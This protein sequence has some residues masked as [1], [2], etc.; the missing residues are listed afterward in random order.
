MKRINRILITAMVLVAVAMFANAN[1]PPAPAG[2]NNDTGNYWVNYTWSKELGDPVDDNVNVT[3]SFNV[4]MNGT[5]YNGT[6]TFLNENVGPGGWANITVWAYNA[7]GNGNMSVG[8]VSDNVQAP[9][10]TTE[11]PHKCGYIPPPMDLSHLDEI[12]VK[13]IQVPDLPS[14]FDWRDSGNVTPVKDQDTCGTCWI[15]GTTSV[16]ESAVLI[17]EGAECIFSEQGVALCVDRSWTY[18]YDNTDDPCGGGGWSWLAAEAFIKKGSVLE[19]CNPY[20]TTALNCD[21]S[22]VCD[23][24]ASVKGVD[25]YRLATDNG[26][27]IDV[28]KN[29]V[30]DHG[31]VTMAFYYNECGNY[32]NATWGTIYDYYPSPVSANH[33]VSIIGWNDSVP[34]PNQSHDGTGAWIVKNSW[35]TDWGNDGFFYLA[36]NS[37]CVE[38]I[39]YLVYKNP[40]P[41]EELLYWDEAG[42]VDDM[43]Y[44]DSRA[45]MASNFTADQSGNLT[46]VDFWTTSNNAEYEIY[47]WDGFFGS[48]LANQTSNCLELGYYSIPLNTPISMDAG[49]QFTVGVNMT[50]PGYN[51][52][53]PVEKEI[54]GWVSPTIQTNVSFIR[55]NSSCS[56]TDMAS[57]EGGENACLRARMVAT[58][59]CTCGDICVNQTGW[60]RD[61]SVFHANAMDPIQEAV[62]DA[63]PGETIH[64]AAGS[65]TENVN[66]GTSHLTLAGEGADVVNVRAYS[67]S[68]H[69]FEVTADYVNISGFNVTGATGSWMAGIYLNGRQHCNISDNRASNN[70]YGIWLNSSSNN[71][72]TNNT[73]SENGAGIYLLSSGDN[74]LTSNNASGNELGILLADSS[75]DNTLTRNNASGNEVGN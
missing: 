68:D 50:T 52:P 40:V 55:H 16:L 62:D 60:W 10:A 1:I 58:F 27:E 73:V 67:T 69:V 37:S 44:G 3:D 17:N 56:W 4:S 25:G 18:L 63:N 53:I 8:N 29:A 26:S 61:G 45:W 22:C 49:Q 54:S 13:R 20:N 30:Y 7:T 32:T 12:P 74:T 59:P 9:S 42:F 5:W 46:H 2:L 38:E 28:I 66:I 15:F 70:Y 19:S 41:G 47:V 43:G 23:D 72:V 11:L 14:S 34:H 31:P 36:Y 75:N 57:P 51:F 33:L 21:G 24:C 35:G 39:A 65:Y 6:A 48:E 64:V 71:T